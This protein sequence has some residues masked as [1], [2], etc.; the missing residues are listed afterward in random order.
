LAYDAEKIP[1]LPYG[2]GTIGIYNDKLLVYK[3]ICKYKD[4]SKTRVVVYGTTPKEC[5]IN[6]RAEENRVSQTIKHKTVKKDT[7]CDVMREWLN[8]VKINELKEQSFS[9]L[10]KTIKNQIETSD[11]GHYRY[12]NITSEDIQNVINKLNEKKYSHSVIKKT[13]DALN[14]F[15]RYISAKEKI[16]NPMLLVVMPTVNNVKA[17]AKTIEFFEQDDIEKFINECSVR[18]HTGAYKYKYGYA[19]AANIYLGLRIGELLALQ[20][21]D[22]D[23]KKNTIYIHRTLIEEKNPA[24][25]KDKPEEMKELGIHKSRFAIQESTKV[26][27]NRYVPINSK[28]KELLLKYRSITEHNKEDDFVI[29]TRNGKTNTT[30]NISDAIKAIEKGAETNTQANGT[31][32]L[33]HTCASLYFR[34]GVPLLTIAQILGNSVEV[35]EKTYVHFIEEQLKEAASKIDI[36]EV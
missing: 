3:K 19:L 22:I 21:K 9:R 26:S 32:V 13:Y 36:I 1:K 28:A 10:E 16:D 33:R 30:K 5:M 24:Y 8:T 7:L 18:F 15:Y 35:L 14:E 20:W 4:G 2:E 17:E 27:K 25:D 29:S 6:M 34:A 12:N 23:F 11:I 31:H